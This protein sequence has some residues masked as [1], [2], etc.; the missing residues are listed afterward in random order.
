MWLHI[1][2]VARRKQKHRQEADSWNPPMS[3]WLHWTWG[4]RVK[5]QTS[6]HTSEPSVVMRWRTVCEAVLVMITVQ[7]QNKLWGSW[8]ASSYLSV[9]AAWTSDT[10]C[11]S[12]RMA[13]WGPLTVSEATESMTVTTSLCICEL[14]SVSAVA[15]DCCSVG[16][17]VAEWVFVSSSSRWG[18]SSAAGWT[19]WSPVNNKWFLKLLS[20]LRFHF[21]FANLHIIRC[22][23]HNLYIIKVK[24]YS[25]VLALSLTSLQFARK[26][27]NGYR[28]SKR[29]GKLVN[30]L[31]G[32]R[33][34]SWASPNGSVVLKD[35]ARFTTLWTSVLCYTTS[36]LH[37]N[38]GCST[39][40][41][42]WCVSPVSFGVTTGLIHTMNSE[43]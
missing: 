32:N 40:A 28:D 3:Q 27:G 6:L 43:V 19:L 2:V 35:G 18:A 10:C 37:W 17:C 33:C 38:C 14:V 12:T 21:L 22:L 25:P 15:T 31:V 39:L 8:D 16:V 13:V 26:M 42:H 11:S 36:Q 9:S 1:K 29:L 7:M 24:L 41:Q 4:S 30:R 20:R 23:F 34:L 5:A